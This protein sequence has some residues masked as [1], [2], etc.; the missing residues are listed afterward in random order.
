MLSFKVRCSKGTY[1]RALVRDMGER[2]G[3]GASLRRLVRLQVGPFYLGEAVGLPE[4][5]VDRTDL[6]LAPD[7]VLLDEPALVL[8]ESELDHLR[9]VR[10]WRSTM[11]GP[12]LARAYTV[13][14][15]LAGLLSSSAGQWRPK[16][17][18]LE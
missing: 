10:T 11:G 16:L 1:V 5:R 15:R 3:I 12:P 4:V 2:L 14:G 18:F 8:G 7:A 17:V 13:G 6:V 9:H